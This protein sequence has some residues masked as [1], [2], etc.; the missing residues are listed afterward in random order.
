[1]HVNIHGRDFLCRLSLLAQSG[2]IFTFSLFLFNVLTFP[3]PDQSLPKKNF[4]DI[5]CKK[6]F[7]RKA[8]RTTCLNLGE[9][10]AFK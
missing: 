5:L 1:M 4:A 3:F 2:F 6:L 10:S 8:P 7:C 9:A